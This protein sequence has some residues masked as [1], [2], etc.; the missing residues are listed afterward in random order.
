[1]PNE[2][3]MNDPQNIWQNQTTEAF[4]M[5]ADQ[6]R[7]EAQM[8]QRKA[9]F[10]VLCSIIIGLAL[11]V[12]F[13]HTFARVHEMIPRMGWGLLSL[14]CIYSAYQAYKWMWPALPSPA[15]TLNSTL[16]SYRSELE[17]RRDYI[18]HIW[19]RAGLTF[20]FLGM[21][22]VVV[23]IL[24]KSLDTP[25]LLVNLAP[26]FLLLALWCVIFFL[27]RKRRQKKLQQEIEQLRGLEQER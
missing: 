22:M 21:A 10:E 20:A 4:K 7:N 12:F 6:L 11:F 25:R 13:A 26:F 5:S 18:R 19:R 15:A 27:R 23:P 17:K 9:R 3:P 24:V 2:F 16:Q 14:W 8:R 1:M